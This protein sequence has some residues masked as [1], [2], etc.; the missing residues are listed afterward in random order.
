MTLE[1]IGLVEIGLTKPDN[2]LILRETLTRIGLTNKEN[3]K[4]YQTCHILYKRK[5]YWLVHFKEMFM[6]DGK[7]SNMT[8]SDIARRNSIINHLL[9]LKFFVLVSGEAKLEP[10]L[11]HTTKN[12]DFT[13]IPYCDRKNWELVPKYTIGSSKNKHSKATPAAVAA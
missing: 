2:F 6:L 5:K 9:E 8:T 1:E 13:I 3:T 4:L 10:Y 7:P 11:P 12:D